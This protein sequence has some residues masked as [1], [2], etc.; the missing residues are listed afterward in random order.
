MEEDSETQTNKQALTFDIYPSFRQP[1]GVLSVP[2]S[3]SPFSLK[4]QLP[5]YPQPFH[6]SSSLG[7]LAA[8]QRPDWLMRPPIMPR[9]WIDVWPISAES[10]RMVSPS[11]WMLKKNEAVG[12]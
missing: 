1:F 4:S 10:E 9:L 11:N 8:E 7:P 12:L 3:V 2:V 6:L 5:S